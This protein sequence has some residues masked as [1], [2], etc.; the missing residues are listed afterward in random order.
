MIINL[1]ANV[2][3]VESTV[4]ILLLHSQA[5]EEET[6]LRFGKILTSALVRWFL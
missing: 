1:K 4:N 5:L 2:D 3:D 6:E